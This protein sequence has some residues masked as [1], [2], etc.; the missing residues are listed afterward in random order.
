MLAAF[1]EDLSERSETGQTLA[2]S[3]EDPTAEDE[4][5]RQFNQASEV[6]QTFDRNI[7]PCNDEVRDSCTYRLYGPHGL[8]TA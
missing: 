1:H 4:D 2:S 5:G 6:P 3:I 8:G 7:L